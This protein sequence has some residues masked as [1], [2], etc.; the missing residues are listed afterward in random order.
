MVLDRFFLLVFSI[1]N[2]ATFSI[3]ISAPTLFD[4]R[5]PLNI[6]VPSLFFFIFYFEN[7]F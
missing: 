1:L 5:E 4:F 6:T 2:M 7:F 3:I